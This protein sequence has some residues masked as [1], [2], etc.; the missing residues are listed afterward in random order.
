M[1]DAELVDLYRDIF[2]EI[3]AKAIPVCAPTSDDPERVRHYIVPVGPIHRAA[4]KLN[5]QMFNGEKHLRAAV[6]EIGRLKSIF[7]ERR[8]FSLEG[9]GFTLREC[10]CTEGF[11]DS[12]TD[13]ACKH[14]TPERT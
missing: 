12:R 14:A 6:E 7:Q 13:G 2:A 5:F 10:G 11:C 4:G 1:S 3:T 8:E 9:T